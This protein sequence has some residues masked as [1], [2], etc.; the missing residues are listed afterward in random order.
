M[1]I[2]RY[3]PDRRLP[4]AREILHRHSR[5]F[6]DAGADLL[7]EWMTACPAADSPKPAS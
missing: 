6:D 3:R 5:A 4:R 1:T 7:D 2:R